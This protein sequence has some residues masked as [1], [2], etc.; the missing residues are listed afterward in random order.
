MAIFGF[1]GYARMGLV[2]IM[3]RGR[4]IVVVCEGINGMWW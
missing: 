2:W 4:V 1:K 3:G